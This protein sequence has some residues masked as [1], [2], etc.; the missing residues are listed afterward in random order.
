MNKVELILLEDKDID[1]I[2][3]AF[4]KIDWHKPRKTYE[5]YIH[6]Q[7]QNI[8]VIFVARINGT[9]CG[10]VT[11]K[12]QTTHQPFSRNNIPEISDLNVLS[13]YRKMGIG[14]KLIQ[15]CEE[16]AKKH[17]YTEIGI[18]VGMTSDYG[19]AQ[20]LYVHLGYVPDGL[21]LYYKDKQLKYSD[22]AKVDDDLVLY[23]KKT[24]CVTTTMF[25]T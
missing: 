16:I 1:E 3:E 5:A 21:G 10:Y 19:S 4:K 23:S 8:L 18:G 12:W 15:A 9:F 25:L 6:E 11:L 22:I 20:R 17:A 7:I 13:Q 14:T 24:S 2:V